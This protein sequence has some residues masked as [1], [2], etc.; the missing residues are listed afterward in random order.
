M[1]LEHLVVLESNDL[2]NDEILL[3]GYGSQFEIWDNF[4]NI[5]NDSSG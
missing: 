3:E 4:N 5:N 2:K 1:S